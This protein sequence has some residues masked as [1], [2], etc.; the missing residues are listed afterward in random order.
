M[1]NVSDTLKSL[2]EGLRETQ[3]QYGNK[4]R[5][6]EVNK[7]AQY[8]VCRN[9]GKAC[10]ELGYFC[11]AVL[12]HSKYPAKQSALLTHSTHSPLL[13]YFWLDESL[14][15]KQ[16][17]AALANDENGLVTISNEAININLG[18]GFSISPTRIGVL[19]VL[20]EFIV[21]IDPSHLAHVE[22]QLTQGGEKDIKALSSHLQK[23]IYE[24]L[25]EHIPQAQQQK[26]F[27][28]VTNWLSSIDGLSKDGSSK[29][30]WLTDENVLS[31]WQ[32]AS[33]D[34][35]SPGY[36]LYASALYDLIDVNQAQQQAQAAFELE[37]SYALGTDADNGEY[38]PDIIDQLVFDDVHEQTSMEWLTQSPKFLN[39]AQYQILQPITEIQESLQLPLSFVRLAVFSKWQSVLVQAKRKSQAEV[40]T[41]LAQLPD[42][43]YH[44][45]TDEL[46]ALIGKITTV[47]QAIVAI[48]NQHQDPRFIG[49]LLP[50]LSSE[51]AQSIKSQLSQVIE[52]SLPVAKFIEQLQQQDFEIRRALD[53]AEKALKANNK[54]GFKQLPP[55]EQLD[56][57]QQGSE[58]LAECILA[59]T[60]YLATLANCWQLSS[61]EE[62][63]RSDLFIFQKR[64][65]QIYEVVND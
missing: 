28:Y 21:G 26:R 4:F 6:E 32:Q 63:Y 17:R 9:Y 65:E 54:D 50:L 47:Q 12:H 39:K 15:P 34:E 40:N 1:Q 10:L 43:N 24:F 51:K 36:V 27:R 52:K 44:S 19:A 55:V 3:G 48:F 57:Y 2:F 13:H 61:A 30:G 11:W 53:E 35:L 49:L 62:K 22:K 31:F 46:S 42:A 41:K 16:V 60:R 33:A 58:A 18:A 59:L 37:H 20:L 7:V 8:L 56:T 5:G 64:F 38:S 25:S 14:S 29:E 45:F 23:I